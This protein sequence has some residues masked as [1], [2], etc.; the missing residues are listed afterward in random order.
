MLH[1]VGIYIMTCGQGGGGGVCWI[2]G[3]GQLWCTRYL[4]AGESRG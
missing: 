2:D 3:V 1:A 4:G